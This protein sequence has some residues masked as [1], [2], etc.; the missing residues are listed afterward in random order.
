VSAGNRKSTQRKR[1]IDGMLHA[2]LRHGYGGAS[3][4]RAIAYAG[5]SRPTFYDYFSDRDDCLLAV[6]RETSQRLVDQI[7]A[8]L[9][10]CQPEQAVHAAVRALIEFSESDPAAARLLVDEALTGGRPTLEAREHTIATIALMVE[11]LLSR[12]QPSAPAPDVPLPALLGGLQWLL[13]P[14]LRR[15]EPDLA[16]LAADIA[17]W[18]NSYSLPIASHR[19]RALEPSAPLAPTSHV[20]DLPPHAPT[21]LGPGRPR[22]TTAEVARNQRDRILYATATVAASKGYAAT[23]VADIAASAGLDRRIFYAHFQDKRQ[24]FLIMHESALRHAMALA[25][26]AFFSGTT[27]PERIWE[28]IHASAQFAASYPVLTRVAFVDSHAVGPAAIQRVEDS[29]AAF[30]IFLEEGHRHTDTPLPRCSLQAIVATI[31]DIGHREALE[32]DSQLMPR[33]VPHAAYIALAPFLGPRM[34]NQFIDGK[35]PP[36]QHQS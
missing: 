9:D 34:A 27:W 5:V 35:L 19:W 14:C 21:P 31:F 33:L 32:R 6:Q 17:S 3:I 26:E 11:R 23:T 13:A 12:A 4:A 16:D 20:S 1:L 2:C 7:R 28:G 22:L 24:A 29:R 36:Q 15:G 8:A 18:L 25:A 30:M 10:G